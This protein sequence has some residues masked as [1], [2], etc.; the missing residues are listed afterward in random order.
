MKILI[1]GGTKFLGRHLVDAALERNHEVTL[2]N[3]GTKYSG[4]KIENVEQIHGDRNIDLE[5]LA[6]R[7]WDAVIDTCGYLPQMV[8]ASAE[9]LKDAVERYVFISSIS[10][11][12]DFSKV[13]FDET[14]ELAKL[15]AEQEKEFA[16]IDPKAELTGAVLGEMYGALKVLCEKEVLNVFG[17]KA[18]IIRP[19]LIVGEY[20]FTDRFTYW[21]MRVARGGDVLAPGNPEKSVQFIDAKDLAE[22]TIEMI[23]SGETG[24]YN[25]TGKPFET[26]FGKLLEEIKAVSESDAKFVWVGES[27]LEK[28][29][30]APWSDLP[31]YLPES[32]E[33][34]RG[35][36]TANVD[37]ALAK[38]LKFRPLQEMIKDTLNWRK[39]QNEEL[40]AGISE[41]KEKELLAKWHEQE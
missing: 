28:E 5:K 6:N 26:T 34:M 25:A 11:Y 7:R 31:L 17:D 38:N 4:E 12:A 1:I 10:A 29:K 13:N 37:K 21:V 36:L 22:W 41:E 14:T 27:F 32:L 2:F 40:K 3:R 20:D 39:P 30:V 33:E 18:L 23:E 8:K 9:F 16:K 15:T 24:F 19:G 35:F